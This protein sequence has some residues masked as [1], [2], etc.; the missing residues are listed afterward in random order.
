MFDTNSHLVRDLAAAGGDQSCRAIH[1]SQRADEFGGVGRAVPRNR[2]Y[3][4]DNH[5]MAEI[6]ARLA[7]LQSQLAPYD[8]LVAERDRLLRVR[9]A[10]LDGAPVAARSRG[11]SRIR[12]RDVHNYLV[13]RPGSRPIEIARA[14]GVPQPTISAHLYRGKGEHFVTEGGLWYSAARNGLPMSSP[15]EALA[16]A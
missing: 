7:E 15:E 5:V 16:A 13:R 4:H 10:M 2:D 3:R 12:R 1:R 8:R 9:A 14:L 11:P 6:E